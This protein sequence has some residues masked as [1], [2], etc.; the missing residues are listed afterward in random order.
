MK[1]SPN[2]KIE[3]LTKSHI[4]DHFDCGNLEL[5]L[6]IQAQARQQQSKKLGSTKVAISSENPTKVLGFYT[7]SAGSIQ[8]EYL[9]PDIQKKL[10]QYPI[11]IARLGRLAVDL[12]TKG[13]GFGGFLLKD[14]LLRCL[15]I[16][17]E[18]GLF[19]VVVDAKNEKA[20]SFYQKYG[21]ITLVDFPMTLFLPLK[22]IEEAISPT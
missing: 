21:F 3:S 15:Q 18:M 12:T 14:A 17:T 13:Q 22:S 20:K 4:R 1:T 2:W 6:F 19:A 11:P 9:P 5:N 7:L 8:F 10:V 16:A